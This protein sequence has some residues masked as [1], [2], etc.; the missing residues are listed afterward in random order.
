MR[1]SNRNILIILL[2]LL[3][4]VV[5]IFF[6]EYQVVR[7]SENGNTRFAIEKKSSSLKVLRDFAVRD[8]ASVDKIYL[9]DKSNNEISLERK[10]G[11]W[12]VND[13]YPA[14]RDLINVLL[15]TIHRIEVANP[16]PEAKRD[17]VLRDMAA[18]AVKCEIYQQGEK[19]KTYYIGGVTQDHMGTYMM[20][21][22]SS[23]PF[24]MEIPGF[25][26]FLT[27][28]Y[29]TSI[30]EWRSRLIFSAPF[31]KI[32]SVSISYPENPQSSFKAEQ[33]GDNQFRLYD[34]SKESYLSDFDTLRV[35]ELIG[36][37]KKFGLEYY[38]TKD[39]EHKLD[40]LRKNESPI[41]HITIQHSDG[42]Q[43]E[44]TCYKRP[45]YKEQLD[46]EGNPYPND[47]ERLF[48]VVSDEL[49]VLQYYVLDPV[50]LPISEFLSDRES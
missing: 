13:A 43:K 34:L 15:E 28:R 29:N 3:A 12:I 30:K 27:T 14:R 17:Y 18:N 23:A 4:G 42:S 20:L 40:S 25:S 8:T 10:N 22:G 48:G 7:K 31:E 5:V 19:I 6:K 41:C 46:D 2:L 35:K 21:E 33:T 39:P 36:R 47:V 1:K 45:N 11:M 32:A 49:V 16:V 26:G 37:F 50:L 44:I 24:E 9:A 38:V